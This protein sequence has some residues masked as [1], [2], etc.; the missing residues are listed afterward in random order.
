MVIEGLCYYF[1]GMEIGDAVEKS[2]ARYV[3]K[4]GRHPAC[5]FIN[6]DHTS[7]PALPKVKLHRVSWLFKNLILVSENENKPNLSRVQRTTRNADISRDTEARLSGE[8]S[9]V[10]E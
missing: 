8:M 6:K 7:I 5:V 1:S 9:K 2:V 4:T 10:P 3:S